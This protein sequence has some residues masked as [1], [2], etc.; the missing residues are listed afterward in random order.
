V[1]KVNLDQKVRK[2]I[3]VLKEIRETREKMVVKDWLVILDLKEIRGILVVKVLIGVSD[4]PIRNLY[5]I[6]RNILVT[7]VI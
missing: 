5:Y 6:R 2:E 4:T 1:R 3:M 7:M